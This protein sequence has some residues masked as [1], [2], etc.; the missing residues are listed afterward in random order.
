MAKTLEQ[1]VQEALGAMSFQILTVQSQL[2][3]EK[4]KTK[5]LEEELT[6]LK[7]EKKP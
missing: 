6:K 3:S 1:F 2:E 5:T 4:E 7:G